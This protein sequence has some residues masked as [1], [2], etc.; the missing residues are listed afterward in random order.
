MSKPV[1]ST[2]QIDVMKHCIG[3]RGDL[4]KRRKYEAYRNHFTTP[5]SNSSWDGIVKAGLAETRSFPQ[6]SGDNPQ[7]YRLN[8]Q[9]LKYLSDLLEVEIVERE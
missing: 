5:N 1:L 8:K 9:G 4:V 7:I 6:G 3:F 2:A